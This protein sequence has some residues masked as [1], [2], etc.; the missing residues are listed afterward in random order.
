MREFDLPIDP[1]TAFVSYAREDLEFVYRLAK[2]L[3]ARARRSGWTTSVRAGRGMVGSKPPSN[4][5][6]RVK[7]DL[8]VYAKDRRALPRPQSPERPRIR[9]P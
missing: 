6:M 7:K 5:G 3:K 9:N 2:D 8:S 4:A 1:S